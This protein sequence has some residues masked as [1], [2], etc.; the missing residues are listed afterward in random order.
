MFRKSYTEKKFKQKLLKFLEQ[1]EDK[2]FLTSCFDLN[3]GIYTLKKEFAASKPGETAAGAETEAAAGTD[4]AVAA[5]AASETDTGTDEGT[6][7]ATESGAGTDVTVE[8]AAGTANA[9][10]TGDETSLAAKNGAGT[11]AAKTDLKARNRAIKRLKVLAKAIKI[12]R[13]GPV[14][15]LPLAIFAAFIAGLVFFFTVMMNPLLEGLLERGLENVFEARCDVRGFHLG[16]LRFRIGMASVTV[17]NRDAPMTNLFETGKI[18]I[19]LRPQAVL[20]GKVYIE[21]LRA[22]SLRF[23]TPRKVSGAIPAYEARRAAR[24]AAPPAP[25]LIDLANFDAMGLLNR[26][27]DK[28]ASPKVFNAAMSA[29][30]EASSRW[31]EQY[32]RAE[33]KVAELQTSAQPVLSININNVKTPEDALKIVSDINT[34]VDSVK[35][36][37]NEVDTIAGNI[38]SDIKTAQD[39]ERSAREALQGDIDHL[40]SYLDLGSGSAFAALEPSIREIL[41]DQAEMYIAYGLRA[42]ETMEK[43]KALQAKIPKSEPKKEVFKGRNVHFPTQSYPVF[44]LETMA[45]DFTINGWNWGFDLHSVSSDPD[46]SNRPTRLN[47]GMTEESGLQRKARF[48]GKANFSSRAQE[49]FST[50]ITGDNF[51]LDLRGDINAAGIG[52]AGFTGR[53]GFNANLSGGR[54]GAAAGGGGVNVGEP[55]LVDPKGTIAEA[56]HEVLSEQNNI[57]LGFQYVH[58]AGGNDTFTLSTNIGD[59]IVDALKR[60]VARYLKQAQDAI[61][62]ALR[63][64]LSAYLDDRWVSKEDLDAVFALI[65]GDQAAVGRLQASLEEKRAEVERKVRGAAEEAVDKAKEEAQRQADEAVRQAEEAAKNAVKNIIPGIKLPF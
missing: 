8:N 65:R 3:E 32:K 61:E 60:I 59:L 37:K 58:P 49:Y 55:R 9:V 46:L 35:S 15:I 12:N 14:K 42:L 2:A 36:A 30:N 21:E 7:L 43:L 52:L 26:E 50:V 25:P 54:G 53:I 45:S 48:E 19:R 1:N 51:P 56:I 27:Y 38:Q 10:E 28:L 47:L 16:L 17:A 33:A 5:E 11:A 18:E 64:K 40:K 44:Y 57:N 39:L 13:L 22:D 24:R 6:G 34:L 63:E 20:R 23:G 29:Y 41:S 31:Q 4:S 62:N